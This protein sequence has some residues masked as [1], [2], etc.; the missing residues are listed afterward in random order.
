MKKHF[1]R[2]S[3]HLETTNINARDLEL[4]LDI[5]EL[6]NQA[7]AHIEIESEASDHFQSADES[8]SEDMEATPKR[9]VRT[10]KPP[11]AWWRASGDAAFA[12]A[13]TLGETTIYQEPRTLKQAKSGAEAKQWEA[14]AQAE[15]DSLAQNKTWDLVPLPKGRKSVGCK[16]VFKLKLKADGSVDRY[17]A[18]LVAKG[19]SQQEGLDFT[20]TFAPVAKFAAIRAVLA[21]AALEDME[22]HQMDV[23]TAF[24]NG[25]LQEE[26]YMDQ[27]E[28][29]IK[30]GTENLVC[31]LRKSLHGLKQASRAWNSVIDKFLKEIGAL[32][33]AGDHCIYVLEQ[34]TS[35]LI[36]ILY[37][38]D[39]I[40]AT[41][42]QEL[43]DR[44]KQAL[45]NKFSMKDLGEVHYFLG[46]QVIR[47]RKDRAIWLS[48][49]RYV[50]QILKTY[51]LDQ[52][53]PVATP[54]QVGDKL[55]KLQEPQSEAEEQEMSAIPYGNAVGSLIYAMLGTR[56]DIAA[57]VGVC[58]QY[59]ANP[60]LQHWKAVKRILRYL[61]GTLD[62]GL[63]LGGK[64]ATASLKGYSDS[65]WGG[66]LDDRKSTT[67]FVF[68]FGGPISWQSKKQP[69]VALSST[70]A[71]YM[72]LTQA[73]KEA[74]WLQGLLSELGIKET[75]PTTILE[76]NQGCIAL[77]KNPTS[78]AR[79]KHIDIRHHFIRETLEN[80]QI[81]LE[82]CPT[83]DMVADILT[84]AIPKDQ[85]EKLRNMLGL[86]SQ[87][88]AEWE[89]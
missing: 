1:W 14:A 32:K 34:E 12:Y 21:L 79:T 54:L 44:T 82:Y 80:G 60:G 30:P 24:L 15:M 63:K 8:E 89:C 6:E 73:A 66:S 9:P 43:L 36:I 23:E 17:K 19:Y 7:P 38:D 52:S 2:S 18:R 62:L 77:A 27:P 5:R 87:V 10:R 69:T 84:K 28:G 25:L 16:W 31:K 41:N 72:A 61:Q 33:C 42:S 13:V 81:K 85:F 26:I 83:T 68:D 47:N 20:E 65:D 11:G 78:H 56:P 70:E 40:L 88:S 76:D 55:T 3:E 49:R 74:I 29:F 48:Q 22:V 4:P 39:L 57:A 71:K 59:M 46:I 75:R 51:N 37:V 45:S 86:H 35:Q 64:N 53:K 58:S 50:E 67:G